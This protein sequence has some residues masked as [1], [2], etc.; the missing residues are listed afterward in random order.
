MEKE[1]NTTALHLERNQPDPTLLEN[2]PL[3][4]HARHFPLTGT[5]SQGIKE[6]AKL[7]FVSNLLNPIL[8]HTLFPVGAFAAFPLLLHSC[9]KKELR[10]CG[11][12]FLVEAVPGVEHGDKG[13]AGPTP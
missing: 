11:A 4:A 5:A 10:D 2:E 1:N 12:L 13:L 8:Y 9:I 3:S 7:L 6:R